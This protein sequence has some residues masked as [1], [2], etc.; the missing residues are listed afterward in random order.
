MKTT[1]GQPKKGK[2]G[3]SAVFTKK[4]IATVE[5]RVEILDWHHANDGNQTAT[6]K[7]FDA[8]Y[9]NLKIR[10]PLISSWLADEEKWR[11]RL[12]ESTTEGERKAKRSRQTQHPEVTEAMDLWVVAALSRGLL[13]T[14][15]VLRQKWKFFA[16]QAEIPSDEQLELSNGWLESFKKRHG[17]KEFKR[18]GEAASSSIE[19]VEAERSRIQKIIEEGG[20]EARDIFNMDE[21]G[22]FYQYA[23]QWSHL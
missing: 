3:D 9:P 20:Y 18:H 19:T 23:Q 6:A 21:T 10:Q 7:H 1:K 11:A 2:V 22:L 17:L 8:I 4:E 15:E 12:A 5:Q 13:L 14:G 16:T